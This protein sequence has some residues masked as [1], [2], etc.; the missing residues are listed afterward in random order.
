MRGT[1]STPNGL[2]ILPQD[3]WVQILDK[4]SPSDTASVIATSRALQVSSEGSLYR[5]VHIDWT[6]PPL[7]RVLALFRAIHKR[8]DLA[9]QVHHVS[10]ITSKLVYP[11]PDPEDEWELPQIDGDW[12][13]LSSLFQ[14]EVNAAKDIIIKAQFPS[15]EMWIH[16]LESGD[17]YAFVSVLLSQLHNLRSLQLDHTFVWQAGF[18]GLMIR[19]ALLSAPENILSQFSQ[20]SVVEYGLNVPGSRKFND[21]RWNFIDAFPVCDPNQFAGW[22]YLPSLKSLEIWIQSFEGISNELSKPAESS[23]LAHLAQLKRLVLTESSVDE[24]DVRKLLLRLSSLKSLHLGLIYPSQD[25]ELDYNCCSPQ[26]PLKKQG[27]LLEGLM[28]IKDTVENLSISLELCPLWWP[29]VW[30]AIER[31]NGTPQ[32]SFKPFKGILMRFPLLRTAELPAVMLFGWT[33]AG[34]PAL[35]ELLPPT[36]RK[37]AIRDNLWCEED[38]E[39]ETDQV[40]E[41]I[42]NFLPF[43][44]SVTPM[45]NKIIIRC[46]GIGEEGDIDPD[47][48]M[49]ARSSCE[50]LGLDIDISMIQYNLSPGLWTMH[51]GLEE[52]SWR[53]LSNC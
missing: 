35:S 49:G 37:L 32:E 21:T 25:K 17:P 48:S 20:L 13:Q 40:G 29:A 19:H 6:R 12:D 7:K 15:S 5:Q 24:D 26:P 10:M 36:L 44:Q 46:F 28:S 16:A 9:E 50:K 27:V 8:P 52:G 33:C 38:Y 43:A 22:F 41:A 23:K 31:D 51:R 1:P 53:D 11:A 4:I 2:E 14:D 34:A 39:W 18:P 47:D 45:L 30:G 42:Q 3:C